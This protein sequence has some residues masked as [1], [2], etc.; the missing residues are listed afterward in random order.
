TTADD[1]EALIVRQKDLLDSA[2]PSA[3]SL[4]ALAL[5]RL[6]A[7][8]GEARYR[9]QADQIL[10][11][12]AGVVPSGPSAFS[13]LLAAVDLR[14][15]GVT[16]IAVAGDRPDLV[17]TVHGRYLPDAVLAWGARADAPLWDGR[18][19]GLAYV[20]H[21]YLCEAPVDTVEGLQALLV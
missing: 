9:H 1:G 21:D 12:V 6:G 18:H 8:T 14:R 2:T 7:L 16:E 5:Y 3:N 17:A 13:H 15:A 4:A 10:Q 11:L 20:C 19:D